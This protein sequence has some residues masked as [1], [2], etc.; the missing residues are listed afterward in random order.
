MLHQIAFNDQGKLRSICYR[1]SISEMLVPYSDPSKSWVWRK[2]FDSGEYGLGYV[3][4]EVNAG[5]DLPENAVT[6]DAVLPT[7]S[8]DLSSDYSN[9]VFF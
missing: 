2:F 4:T 9:R 5:K 6:L 7:A 1:A 8:L 3:S